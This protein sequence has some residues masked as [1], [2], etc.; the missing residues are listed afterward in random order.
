MMEVGAKISVKNQLYGQL[1]IVLKTLLPLYCRMFYVLRKI[2]CQ[3]KSPNL[4][5][6]TMA[7]VTFQLLI[8]KLLS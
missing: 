5:F 2:T 7:I 4:V 3:S 8:L 1:E 6:T